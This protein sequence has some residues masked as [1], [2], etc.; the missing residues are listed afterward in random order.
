MPCRPARWLGWGRAGLSLSLG[1]LVLSA[2]SAAQPPGGADPAAWLGRVQAAASGHSYQG[3]MMVGSNGV[4][5]STRLVH[6]CE[7]RHRYERVEALDGRPRVQLRHN[8]QL[9]TLWP[10][11]KQAR[12]ESRDPVAEFPSLA[13]TAALALDNYE[14]APWMRD[15]IAGREADVLMLKPRDKLRYAQRLW[16][17]R[18]T[19]LLLR[20][21]VVGTGG[22]VL[23]SSAFTDVQIG[24]K[25]PAD[26]VLNPMRRL[27]GY[28]LLRVPSERTQI[29]AEGWM[30]GRPVPGF[31]LVSCSKR[32]L[33]DADI[34]VKPVQVLQSV[35]SDGL[36]QVSV[37]I[38]PFDPMR[39]KQ[40]MGT[41]RGATHTVSSRQGDWWF[42]VVGEVPMTTAQQFS[43]V[44][45][46]RR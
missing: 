9:I 20:S 6:I 7:G 43:T 32:P 28:K 3:T 34:Q 21:D 36:A 12:S 38:E 5:S 31:A 42:T 19:G 10:D 13:G 25:S 40:A 1:L 24:S 26:L 41:G 16:A 4:A 23:E 44:L 11:S 30:I 45:E 33:L 35:F 29:E 14:P 22:D 37:F 17:D 8:D 15:R 18:E 2:S 27:D 39:H 46:R